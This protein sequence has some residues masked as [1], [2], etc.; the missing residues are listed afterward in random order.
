MF[1]LLLS[2]KEKKELAKPEN[3]D[4]KEAWGRFKVLAGAGIV[5]L[6]FAWLFMKWA[7]RGSK[8]A[9]ILIKY[10][11]FVPAAGQVNGWILFSAWFAPVVAVA[12]WAS[13]ITE[14]DP[15]VIPEN[16]EDAVLFVVVLFFFAL[17][18]V[19]SIWLNHVFV[20]WLGPHK[21]E[22]VPWLNHNN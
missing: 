7:E 17:Y 11:P 15:V 18:A 9:Q 3:K 20:T 4:K 19:Q 2:D 5:G 16:M 22:D 12:A 13:S 21:D 10:V 1:D 6:L 8:D 14:E